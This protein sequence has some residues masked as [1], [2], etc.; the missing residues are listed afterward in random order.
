MLVMVRIL[1]AED[2]GS[3]ALAQSVIG[4]VSVVSFGTLILHVLQ[5]RDPGSI[6]WQIHFTAGA[7]V[8]ILLFILSIFGALILRESHKY[9]NAAGPLA[10]LALTFL[11]EIPSTLRQRQLETQHDW[12]RLRVLLMIGTAVGLGTGLL[13]ALIGGGWWALVVQSPLFGLPAALDLFFYGRW[14]PNW[15]WSWARYEEAA[16]FGAMRVGSA[17]VIRAKLATE[18]ILIAGAYDFAGLGVFTRAVGLATLITGRVGTLTMGALYSV[19]TRN[20][21]GSPEFQRVTGLILRGVCWIT[22]PMAVFLAA[23]ANDV[24]DILYGPRWF[25]VV[26]ILPLAVIGVAAAGIGTTVSSLLLANGQSRRCLLIDFAGSV[27][28]IVLALWLI[29]FGVSAYITALAANSSFWLLV[30]V[31]ALA[32]TGGI[33]YTSILSSFVPALIASLCA[34]LVTGW[35]KRTVDWHDSII[36]SLIVVAIFY[37]FLCFFILRFCFP[38]LCYELLSVAPG[39]AAVLRVLG[40]KKGSRSSSSP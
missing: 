4:L 32:A 13:I 39:G 34:I 10:A 28:A 12:V 5:K 2:Y 36:F 15:S 21:V 3:V 1:S 24:V 6:D 23:N 9:G 20:A 7:V 37:H 29:P 40:P 22:I 17:A 11:I 18:N 14:R 31:G 19:V 27:V 33:R 8:N 16:R 38:S 26:D 35:I 25:A 30:T